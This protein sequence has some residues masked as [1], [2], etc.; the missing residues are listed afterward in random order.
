[1]QLFSFTMQVRVDRGEKQ[2]FYFVERVHGTFQ[3]SRLLPG[4]A[5][6]AAWAHA[7]LL[8]FDLDI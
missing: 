4:R 3:K 2:N 1:M 7:R 5:P 6:A 8:R